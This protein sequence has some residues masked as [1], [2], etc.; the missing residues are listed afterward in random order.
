[1]SE[2]HAVSK[3]IEKNEIHKRIKVLIEDLELEGITHF[4]VDTFSQYDDEGGYD[5]RTES[6]NLYSGKKV[7]FSADGEY[8]DVD[9]EYMR[10]IAAKLYDHQD[11]SNMS[12]EDVKDWFHDG[13]SDNFYNLGMTKLTRYEYDGRVVKVDY[14][15]PYEIKLKAKQ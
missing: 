14:E 3:A 4:E 1:M 2:H 9:T 7:V 12:R 8:E 10:K 6:I 13:I 5:L 11:F 15:F